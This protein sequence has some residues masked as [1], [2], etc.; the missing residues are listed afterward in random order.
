MN[1]E[2][3]LSLLVRTEQ[4]NNGNIKNEGGFSNI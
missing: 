2:G 3:V 4:M 1:Y